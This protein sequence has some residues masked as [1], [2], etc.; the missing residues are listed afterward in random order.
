MQTEENS[1]KI[2]QTISTVE[3]QTVDLENANGQIESLNKAL[4]VLKRFSKIGAS[5]SQMA[6]LGYNTSGIYFLDYDGLGEGY[7]PFRQGR[8]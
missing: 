6:K 2:N 1:L 7:P 3:Q 5:C 4:K 8:L